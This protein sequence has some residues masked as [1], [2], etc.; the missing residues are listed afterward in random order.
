MKVKF[1]IGVIFLLS[2]CLE[3]DT[4]SELEQLN[5]EIKKIDEFLAEN[6]EIQMI[7]LL[8]MLLECV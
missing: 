3:S 1:L 4:V 8:R 6:P 5:K 7:S 2:S